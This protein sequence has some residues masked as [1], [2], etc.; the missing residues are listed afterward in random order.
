MFRNFVEENRA[1][2]EFEKLHGNLVFTFDEEEIL[3]SAA[4][5]FANFG[6]PLT[7]KRFLNITRDIFKLK[8]KKEA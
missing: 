2:N 8:G 7:R 3:V 1:E 6:V 4:L 5:S